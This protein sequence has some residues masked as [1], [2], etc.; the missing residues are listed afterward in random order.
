MSIAPT[1]FRLPDDRHNRPHL[2]G[3]GEHATMNHELLAKS[4]RG[5]KACTTCAK[6]KS[7]CYP[8]PT[9]R[10]CERCHR[11]NKPCSAQT[12]ALPRKRKAPKPRRVADLEKRLEELTAVVRKRI[13]Q[14]SEPADD[15]GNVVET[16]GPAP[17]TRRFSFPDFRPARRGPGFSHIFASDNA[18]YHDSYTEQYL[19]HQQQKTLHDRTKNMTK[20]PCASQWTAAG[21]MEGNN[22]RVS[23]GPT[24]QPQ[25]SPMM[26]TSTSSSSFSPSK[27]GRSVELPQQRM[28]DYQRSRGATWHQSPLLDSA[29]SDLGT[30]EA[31]DPWYYPSCDEAHQFLYGFKSH[32][33]ALFPFVVVPADI[34]SEELRRDKPLLW[35]AIMMQGLQLDARRQV[36]MGEELLGSIVA[37]AFI[38]AQKSLDLLQALEILVSWFHVSP[39]SVQLTNLLYLMRS[40]CVSLGFNE[41]Q[42]FSK[43]QDHTVANLEQ[44]RAFTGVYYLV[45]MVFATN[46]KPDAFMHDTYLDHCCRILE[47]RMEYPTDQRVVLLVRTQQLSQSI[48]MTLAFRDTKTSLPLSLIVRSFKHEI[49]KLKNTI[50]ENLVDCGALKTQIHIAEILLY[51][52]GLNEELAA[53]LAPTDR[54][55][56]LWECLCATKSML[57]ARFDEKLDGWARSIVLPSFDYT[58]AMLVCLKLCFLQLPGWD[59]RLVRKELNL[60]KYFMTRIGDIQEFTSRRRKKVAVDTGSDPTRETQTT[61]R[62][63]FQD[64]FVRLHTRLAQLRVSILAELC[65]NLP[66]E[67]QQAKE[68]GTVSPDSSRLVDE[69]TTLPDSSTATTFGR[70][71]SDE[72]TQDLDDSF[73]Q[74]WYNNSND[75]ETGFGVLLGWGADDTSGPICANGTSHVHSH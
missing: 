74:D 4:S 49:C 46:K 38:Q 37:T 6:A 29:S 31:G 13:P 3:S 8:G 21:N 58:Y 14:P 15:G 71:L 20:E 56:L 33:M 16:E 41:S 39:Q 7:R 1:P 47:E 26:A 25:R 11:L 10:I 53:G 36:S 5:P 48:S 63:E 54:L 22:R 64:P 2:I 42:E 72:T 52:V 40:V 19:R 35:Q 44:I 73:R 69:A 9:E 51:E 75:W 65:A 45:T 55:E 57:E 59:L 61:G 60:D 62:S 68:K 30:S 66:P 34:T 23:R 43:Q 24:E 27:S 70:K 50:P 67:S 28:L 12:P 17:Q 32:S 18:E